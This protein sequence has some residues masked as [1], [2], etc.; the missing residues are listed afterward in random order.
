MDS[1]SYLKQIESQLEGNPYCE[2]FIQELQDHT[3]DLTEDQYLDNTTI[4]EHFMKKQFGDPKHVKDDFIRI[5]RPWQKW[6]EVGE[7]LI[8]GSLIVIW[9]S[10]TPIFSDLT[11]YGLW[12]HFLTLLAFLLV[13][14]L[15]IWRKIFFNSS[16][17]LSC[18]K[19]MGLVFAPLLIFFFSSLWQV[20]ELYS[21]MDDRVVIELDYFPAVS[22]ISLLIGL[23]SYWFYFRKKK[24]NQARIQWPFLKF[25]KPIFL[26]YVTA[27]VSIK[28]FLPEIT[29]NFFGPELLLSWELIFLPLFYFEMGIFYTL[30]NTLFISYLKVSYFQIFILSL[31]AIGSFT[32]FLVKKRFSWVATTVLIY[33]IGLLVIAEKQVYMHSNIQVD[34]PHVELSTQVEQRQFGPFYGFIRYQN[35][36]QLNGP[37]YNVDRQNEQFI[38]HQYG[39]GGLV[40][41]M[42]L[43]AENLTTQD[44]TF[45]ES[46]GK[47]YSITPEWVIF[48]SINYKDVRTVFDCDVEI[49]GESLDLDDYPFP[50]FCEKLSYQGIKLIESKNSQFEVNDYVFSEDKHQLLISISDGARQS[51]YLLDLSEIDET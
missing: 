31:F 39:S 33:V 4:N 5:T 38:I 23:L 49:Q 13:P 47:I 2:R 44:F 16:R 34:V 21:T 43:N 28:F 46:D 48:G 42:D 27:Y 25:L 24:G 40:Q 18:K 11:Y 45:D 51:V 10:I 17:L 7:A 12:V 15:F 30:P 37:R 41:S 1:K 22:A 8:Y 29:Y 9:N 50:P 35:D 20:I 26:A 19:M 14:Y 36:Y 6:W 3:E 32:Y